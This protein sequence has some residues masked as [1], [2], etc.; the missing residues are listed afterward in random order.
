MSTPNRRQFIENSLLGMVAAT[1]ALEGDATGEA[2]ELAPRSTSPNEKLGIA[3]LGV[4]QRGTAHIAAY[5]RR[6]DVE[7]LWV[8]DVD[9]AVAERAA[10]EIAS[11][12]GRRPNVTQ[13]LREAYADPLVDIVSIATPNHWHALAGIWA[14]Q[15][16]KDV[17][18]EKPVSHNVSEGRRIVDAARKY[19]RICQT[20]TQS[21]SMTGIQKAMQHLHEGKLGKVTLAR[22]LCYKPRPSIGPRGVYP[23]PRGVDY[24]LWLGPAEEAAVTR[25][26]FHYD[27]HWQWPYGNGDLGNQGVHQ[28]D[29]ARWGLGLNGLC[30][31]VASFGG[32]FGYSDAGDTPNTQVVV[33]DY[34]DK[35]LLFEVRGLKTGPYKDA[36]TGVVFEGSEGIMVIAVYNAAVYDLQGKLIQTFAGGD[37]S[38][39]F[40]NFIAAV[41]SRKPAE[42]NADI[43][44]GHLSSALCHLGN[45]SHRLGEGAS[46]DDARRR[47]VSLN[48]GDVALEA[49]DRMLQHLAE[50]NVDLKSSNLTYGASLDFDPD[51]ERFINNDRA[52]ALLT[53]EY[54]GPYVVPGENG[55]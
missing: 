53:R 25:P 19:R 54:R 24:D 18:V 32:R 34:G 14:M 26:Q 23:I 51:L 44:E 35:A 46:P 21:R 28:M 33:H 29:V 49:F 39:H 2:G 15:Q 3:V 48:H 20:G 42:L 8:V 47:I 10:D 11:R 4:N 40:D 1:A 31:S 43:A 50:N 41:R 55:I 45:I 5:G 36:L 37:E 38:A 22:G 12:Q 9:P 30:K 7:M 17:Y 6:S 16:G 13:D 27:W 52:D